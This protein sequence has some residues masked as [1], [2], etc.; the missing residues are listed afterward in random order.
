M[1]SFLK[2]LAFC[3][4]LSAN[5]AHAQSESSTA[6]LSSML[7][8]ELEALSSELEERDLSI[9][10]DLNPF[11]LRGD[12][13]GD[14]FSD[15]AV[16]VLHKNGEKGIYISHGNAQKPWFIAMEHPKKRM[17]ADLLIPY[18]I[19]GAEFFWHVLSQKEAE[20]LLAKDNVRVKRLL[21]EVIQMGKME[22]FSGLIFWEGQGYVWNG[23]G[24]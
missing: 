24:C 3:L 6:R 13:N 21:G 20:T 8:P 22:A 23:G 14:H 4:F 11:Y 5:L 17:E 10:T 9:H 7:P 12:F 2:L 1:N 15:V 18:G 16:L 19:A